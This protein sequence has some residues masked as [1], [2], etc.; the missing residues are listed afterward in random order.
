MFLD[1]LSPK[2]DMDSNASDASIDV[3]LLDDKVKDLCNMMLCVT[4]CFSVRGWHKLFSDIYFFYKTHVNNF[5][6][7]RC[8][9]PHTKYQQRGRVCGHSPHIKYQQRDKGNARTLYNT[10]T[11]T[12]L[13]T[14]YTRRYDDGRY[15]D[16][17]V[18]SILTIS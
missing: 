11:L 12:L 14:Q 8:H 4:I 7:L 6:R 18:T 16:R 3:L 1:T 17:S 10:P 9:S 13:T 5:A 15:R 2:D